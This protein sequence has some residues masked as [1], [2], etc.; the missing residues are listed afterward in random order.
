MSY[1]LY[2]GRLFKR[3]KY[4]SVS[5]DRRLRWGIMAGFAAVALLALHFGFVHRRDSA[6]AQA[7]GQLR[8]GMT[9]AQVQ[10]VLQPVRHAKLAATKGKSAYAFYGFDEFVT[11]VMEKDGQD[12]RVARVVHEPDEGPLWD[13]F[14]RGW[15]RRLR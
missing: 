7:I 15:E 2:R 5:S 6:V 10:Q 13:R 12:A 14:R 1:C 11:V 9:E 3:E 8:P 4:M